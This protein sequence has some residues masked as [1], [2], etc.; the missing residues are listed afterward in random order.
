MNLEEIFA[1]EIIRRGREYYREGRVKY[2]VK[3]GSILHAVVE[4]SYD[5]TLKI[6]L[7]RRDV[8]CNC[9]YGEPCK[10]AVAALTAYENGEY[11]DGS[12]IKNSLENMDK[13]ELADLVYKHALKDPALIKQL[14]A[15]ESKRKTSKKGPRTYDEF[16][17]SLKKGHLSY[18][19]LIDEAR[20]L[21]GEDKE[22]ILYFLN[23]I[24][25]NEDDI[26]SCVPEDEHYRWD[27]ENLDYEQL[28]EY[29]SDALSSFYK[30]KPAAEEYDK[31]LKIKEKETY[32]DLI[33]YKKSVLENYDTV[34]DEY[35]KKLLENSDYVEYLLKQGKK[36]AALD[37][38]KDSLQKFGILQTVDPKKAL[39][40]GLKN[41]VPKNSE[42]VAEYMI[43]I[44][45]DGKEILPVILK[46]ETPGYDLLCRVE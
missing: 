41:L 17:R 12:Q 8:N 34:P 39:N 45:K 19:G 3:D 37:V 31:L 21:T 10:H 32:L 30:Q 28:T 35:A 20:S 46:S 7:G 5:Y 18:E 14:S 6:D 11:L 24:T 16:F 44:K 40:Y 36:D 25:E 9:P 4:G 1:P 43:T 15:K 23:R 33:D 13:K 26:L 27:S 22:T 38:C 42:E 29:L 2:A